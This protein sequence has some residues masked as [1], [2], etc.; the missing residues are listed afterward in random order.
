MQ[1]FE[2]A[3]INPKDLVLE[4][5]ENDI[6]NGRLIYG[7][8]TL[9]IDAEAY[10]L[11]LS[12]IIFRYFGYSE[13]TVPDEISDMYFE[14]IRRACLGTWEEIESPDRALAIGI[15]EELSSAIRITATP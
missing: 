1:T 15:F 7:L 11:S 9:R 4:L 6:T 5:I 3:Y 13:Q 10:H 14:L 8:S 2:L 12:K